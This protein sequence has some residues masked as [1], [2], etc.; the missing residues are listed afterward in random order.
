MQKVKKKNKSKNTEI[1]MQNT[2]PI[3]IIILSQSFFYYFN[4]KVCIVTNNV[5][6]N[7]QI[8]KTKFFFCL[9]LY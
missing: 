9:F 1:C 8:L 6:C 4:T 7:L 5:V 2:G 3:Y